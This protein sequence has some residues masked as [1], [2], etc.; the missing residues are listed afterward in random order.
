MW[1]SRR[2]FQRVWEGWKAGFMA[3]HAFHT[4]SFPWPDLRVGE[5]TCKAAVRPDHF[6]LKKNV[7]LLG[8]VRVPAGI[9][10]LS[11]RPIASAEF[12]S[13]SFELKSSPAE[14]Q[15]ETLYAERAEASSAYNGR[16]IP[17]GVCLC[18]ERP[19]KRNQ[20]FNR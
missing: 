4:L 2:D 10:V 5:R 20:Y 15:A 1:E 19:I 12:L 7:R 18:L 8:I 11:E 3:F 9:P 17:R 16:A 13:H 14:P 6:A